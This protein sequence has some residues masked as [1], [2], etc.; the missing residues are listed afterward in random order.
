MTDSLLHVDEQSFEEKILASPTPVLVD[1]GATWCG[2]CRQL[3]PVLAELAEELGERAVLAKVDID[4][5]PGLAQRCGVRAA[6]TILFF[7]HGEVVDR[8]VGLRPRRE[9]FERL[10][11]LERAA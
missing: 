3:E 11:A 6:P 10:V 9:L 5:S 2:P 4:Q 1:F 8:L 7:F